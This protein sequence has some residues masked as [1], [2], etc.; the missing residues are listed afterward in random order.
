MAP[1]V[2]IGFGAGL[3]SAVLFVSSATGTMLAVILAYVTP[4]PLLLAGLGWGLRAS[5]TGFGAGLFLTLLTLGSL[6]AMSYALY[7]GIPAVVLTYLVFLHRRH[8]SGG[9]EGARLEWYPPGL[10]VAHSST[11]AGVLGAVA[12]MI[13]AFAGP[14]YDAATKALVEQTLLKVI[15]PAADG[16]QPTPEQIDQFAALVGRLLPA[17]TAGIWLLI[18]LA[19]LWVA[20]KIAAMSER[21]ARPWPDFST[22]AYP[23]YLGLGLFASLLISLAPG[24]LGILATSFIGA[25]VIAYLLMG[26]VIIH[27]ITR[28][29]RYQILML[30]LLYAGIFLIGWVGLLVAL[31]GLS[32]PVLG[33]R[34]RFAGQQG[35]DRGT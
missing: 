17:A 34:E 16:Q 11:M 18:T 6:I 27:T 15:L 24:L 9:A 33:L 20:G 13:L 3:V 8:E 32:D 14:G 10:I 5:V 28:G 22:M 7:V 35:R 21:L 25:F 4:L 26:L 29:A 12:V 1:S 2:L 19:N 23:H 30:I 31:I